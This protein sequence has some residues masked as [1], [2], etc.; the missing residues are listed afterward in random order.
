MNIQLGASNIKR[1]GY[2]LL[3]VFVVKLL[4][5]GSQ[6]PLCPGHPHLYGH[7]VLNDFVCTLRNQTAKAEGDKCHSYVSFVIGR[8]FASQLQYPAS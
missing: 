6:P 2:R 5:R 1:T 7:T 3:T 4:R 8:Q